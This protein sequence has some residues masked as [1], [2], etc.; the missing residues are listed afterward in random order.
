LSPR[1]ISLISPSGISFSSR[2]GKS[3]ATRNS[4]SSCL[5]VW[6]K[7]KEEWKDVGSF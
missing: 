1:E 2:R 5:R 4:F 6:P 3:M 7:G